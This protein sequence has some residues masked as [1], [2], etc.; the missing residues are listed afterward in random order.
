MKRSAAAL[1]LLILLSLSSAPIARADA[2][3]PVVHATTS[4][5]TASKPGRIRCRAVLELPL[6]RTTT[7]RLAWAELRFSGGDPSV[8]PL[9]GRLGLLDAE[10]RDDTRVVWSF[11]VAAAEVGERMM[12]L[13]LVATLEPKSGGAPK[14]VMRDVEVPV[15]VEP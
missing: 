11:S 6:D 2:A 3:P 7:T 9:R 13:R 10:A 15:R 12:R 4:C 14:L 8:T 1:I 5:I